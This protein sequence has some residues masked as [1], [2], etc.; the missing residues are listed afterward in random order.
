MD[1]ELTPEEL[2]LVESL[3][4]FRLKP[5]L[6]PSDSRIRTR[7]VPATE[8]SLDT[9]EMPGT[10][11]LEDLLDSTGKKLRATQELVAGLTSDGL[12]ALYNDLERVH[13]N[14]LEL[15]KLVEACIQ[16]KRERDARQAV[17]SLLERGMTFKRI[18][19]DEMC[20]TITDSGEIL[21]T[22]R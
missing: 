12:E 13:A 18:T 15:K 9:A 22:T 10:G 3:K 21:K 17:T 16:K 1:E 8:P 7:P 19:I 14:A 5:P 20:F 2:Q 4:S 6:K 11:S